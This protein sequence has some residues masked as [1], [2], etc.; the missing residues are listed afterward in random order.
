VAVVGRLAAEPLPQPAP[1]VRVRL[2]A[3]SGV[4]FRPV[5]IAQTGS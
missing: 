2:A 1:D 5:P 3:C 4:A